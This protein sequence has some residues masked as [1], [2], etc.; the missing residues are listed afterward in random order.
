[1]KFVYIIL[2]LPY[3][4]QILIL[5]ISFYLLDF[6]AEPRCYF[7]PEEH[8][9]L[10]TIM[11]AVA[12]PLAVLPPTETKLVEQNQPTIEARSEALL[13]SVSQAAQ[14]LAE[15]QNLIQPPI[16]LVTVKDSSARPQPSSQSV[17]VDDDDDDEE[18]EWNHSFSVE[19][20]LVVSE[21]LFHFTLK[22]SEQSLTV[23]GMAYNEFDRFEGQPRYVTYWGRSPPP[24]KPSMHLN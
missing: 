18:K 24:K 20:P 4:P 11:A 12:P 14:V 3:H 17:A 1:M 23:E 13:A 8:P 19:G 6:H 15:T 22:G 7:L 5:F 16:Q 2:H 21:P 9:L 10:A